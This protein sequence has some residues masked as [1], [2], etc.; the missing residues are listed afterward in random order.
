M[1]MQRSTVLSL[2]S[3]VLLFGN[4]ASSQSNI[5]VNEVIPAKLYNGYLVVVQ[6]SI[7]SLEKRNLV[8]DTGAYPSIIDRDVAKKLHLPVMKDELRVVDRNINSLATLLPT[9]QVGPIQAEGL[10]VVV[11]DLT[12]LSQTFGVRIDALIGFDVLARSSFRI[13][14]GQK[15]VTFG[16]VEPLPLTAPLRWTDS[17]A[18][19]DLKVNGES[20]HLLLDTGAASLLLFAQHLPWAASYAGDPHGYSNL[21]GHFTLRQVKAST[22]ELGGTSLGPGQV[23]I[24][25]TQNMSPYHFD[26]LL[27]TGALPVRQIAFDFEHQVFAWEPASSRADILRARETTD[28][29]MVLSLAATASRSV[30]PVQDGCGTTGSGSLCG[31]SNAMRM[32]PPR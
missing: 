24:S 17:M 6:G 26:G 25:D 2:L 14:Y 19:V 27:S 7:G 15:K 23:F 4:L 1:A 9:L 32:A 30:V 16:P 29:R 20:A 12:S 5:V 22:L 18:C 11:E 3:A 31:M 8:I 10:K 28:P 13:D 21:G